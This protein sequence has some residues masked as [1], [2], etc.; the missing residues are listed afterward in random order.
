MIFTVPMLQELTTRQRELLL[1]LQSFLRSHQPSSLAI[2]DSDI[3]QASL[4]LAEP[5]ET[6]S[7]GIIYEHTAKLA[8]AAQLG[9]EIKTL[10]ERTREKGF[11]ISD[12]AIATVL[13][14]MERGWGGAGAELVSELVRHATQPQF[15]Y[16]HEWEEGDCVVYVRHSLAAPIPGCLMKAIVHR[17]TAAPGTLRRGMTRRRTSA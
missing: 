17:T 13:R 1:L 14:R 6:A 3:A 2:V 8:A 10:I 12:A 5:Y 15:I 11:T 7:R 9:S 4:A 16:V